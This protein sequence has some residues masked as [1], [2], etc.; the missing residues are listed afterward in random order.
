MQL[1]VWNITQ[2]QFLYVSYMMY[3]VL[4]P[5][6]IFYKLSTSITLFSGLLKFKTDKAYNFM[7]NNK[8]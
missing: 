8:F 3:K 1:E 2:N 5:S 4:R 6:L 7:R